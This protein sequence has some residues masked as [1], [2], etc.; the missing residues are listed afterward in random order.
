[1][2]DI[3]EIAP[4]DIPTPEGYVGNL[5]DDQHNSLVRMWESYF[6]ICDRARGQASK[7]SGFKEENV[8]KDPKKSGIP[9]DDAAKDEAKRQQE[10]QGMK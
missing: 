8:G 3:K 7:G 2:T 10:Q 9:E 5:T 4:A 1:M 6:D